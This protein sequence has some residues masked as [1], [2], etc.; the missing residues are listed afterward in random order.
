MRY[1]CMSAQARPLGWVVVVRGQHR[2]NEYFYATFAD[3]RDAE[4]HVRD[5]VQASWQITVEALRELS[6]SEID[7]LDIPPGKVVYGKG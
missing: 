7:A 2:P 5:A 3:P 4:E 1:V 6:K